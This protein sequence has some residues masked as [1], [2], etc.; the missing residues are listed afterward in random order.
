MCANS[1]SR[2]RDS[3]C[4]A[5]KSASRSTPAAQANSVLAVSALSLLLHKFTRDL[6]SD[7]LAAGNSCTGQYMSHSRWTL[8]TTDTVMSLIDVTYKVKEGLL[9]LCQQVLSSAGVVFGTLLLF[10]ILF[11]DNMW[12]I[13]NP[14]NKISQNLKQNYFDKLRK[15]LFIHELL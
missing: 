10:R 15:L 1:I 14:Y 7:C 11:T 9:G 2:A 3:I 8:V 5:I 13:I 4:D 6:D 12:I